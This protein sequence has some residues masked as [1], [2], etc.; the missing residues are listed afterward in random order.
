MIR[1]SL[2]TRHQFDKA[3][4]ARAFVEF[5]ANQPAPFK[6]DRF[7]TSE[8]ARQK[9][10]PATY[11]TAAKMLVD[12]GRSGW[13]FLKASKHKFSA[14]IRWA[15][16]RL[17]EWGFF[18][19]ED[20]EQK[21][22]VDALIA[23]ISSLCRL[24][25]IE[26]GGAAP[27]EDWKAKNWLIEEGPHGSSSERVGVDLERC[28]PGIYWLTILGESVVSFFGRDKVKKCPCAR[29]V[30]LDEHGCLILVRELPLEGTLEEH[31]KE[32]AKVVLELGRQ[33][34]FDLARRNEPCQPILASR[35]APPPS[36]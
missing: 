29:F 2:W 14:S 15:E 18:I 11:K 5:V 17:A 34:F 20:L 1:I 7:G 28:L 33:Y 26:F 12:D 10:E 9:L 8:P 24:V 21:D 32:D 23:F 16:G 4:T 31:L 30:D 19:D 22:E 13:L 25:P 6:F 35:N 36:D 27:D 3:A